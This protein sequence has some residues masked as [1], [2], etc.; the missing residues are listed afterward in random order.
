LEGYSAFLG[1]SDG[2][3]RDP[4]RQEGQLGEIR[5][6]KLDGPQDA[7]R[8]VFRFF[9]KSK[10]PL[11]HSP[12]VFHG[13]ESLLIWPLGG[14][15]LLF[16]NFVENTYFIRKLDSGY[17]NGCQVACHC[18]FSPCGRYLH[19]ASLDG[20]VEKDEDGD[21]EMV[22]GLHIT[23]HRLSSRKPTR[24]PPR[25]VHRVS[26]TLDKT[27]NEI[28][29]LLTLPYTLT[30]T[31]SH[32]YVTENNLLLKV[33]RV[34]LHRKENTDDET[35][36]HLTSDVCVN[37]GDVF[38]PMS[39]ASRKIYFFNQA[40]QKQDGKAKSKTKVKAKAKEEYVATVFIGPS[41]HAQ[42]QT[43]EVGVTEEIAARQL[44]PQ[45]AHLTASQFEGWRSVKAAESEDAKKMHKAETWRGGLLHAKFE[46]FDRSEDCDIVPYIGY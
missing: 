14:G 34:P 4:M 24:S 7:P 31:S 29:K 33:R 10:L 1:A 16:A 22:L 25:L 5:V 9:Q 18:R 15:E 45:G 12:P 44:L 17:R 19:I 21:A 23:T 26:L 30:W 46:K 37:T 41:S 43:P 36:R 8:R 27:Y 2:K 6:F 11:S 40:A 39:A 38:L 20:R 42:P 28:N 35:Y 3:N 32:L 13:R